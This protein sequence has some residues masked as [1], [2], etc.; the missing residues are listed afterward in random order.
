MTQ[1]FWFPMTEDFPGTLGYPG[2]FLKYIK[3]LMTLKIRKYSIKLICEHAL[4]INIDILLKIEI[5][6]IF[7]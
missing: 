7:Y 4:I 2:F 1:S 6:L 5:K 3:K